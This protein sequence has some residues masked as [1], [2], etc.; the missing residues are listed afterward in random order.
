LTFQ[1]Q[2]TES[3]KGNP[4]VNLTRGFP[5]LLLNRFG[6]LTVILQARNVP[7]LNGFNDLILLYIQAHR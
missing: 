7:G 1:K 5:S 2:K 4:A 6:F 3:P